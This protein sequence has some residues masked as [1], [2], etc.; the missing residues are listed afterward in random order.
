MKNDQKSFEKHII[1]WIDFLKKNAAEQATSDSKAK[2]I[3]FDA[4]PSNFILDDKND[5][6]YIDQEW[7]VKYNLSLGYIIHRY[8]ERI[9]QYRNFIKSNY[10]NY[11]GMVNAVFKLASL[12]N[13]SEA[14]LKKSLEAE[15]EI[16]EYITPSKQVQK[17]KKRTLHGIKMDIKYKLKMFKKVFSKV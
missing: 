12:K 5:L 15:K 16:H 1:Q 8:L 10:S 9:K 3:Y 13:I 2:D 7:E 14:E 17:I 4:I 6:H 11:S